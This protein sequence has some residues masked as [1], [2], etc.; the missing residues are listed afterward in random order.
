EIDE[1]ER[2]VAQYSEDLPANY[3]ELKIGGLGLVNTII[4]LKLSAGE[5]VG[6]RI[7]RNF[8]QGT[9]VTLSGRWSAK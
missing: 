2:K 1:L 4:R 6:Y 7:A 5:S 9:T 8:P 3:S